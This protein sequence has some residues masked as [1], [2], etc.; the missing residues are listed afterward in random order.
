MDTTIIIFAIALIGIIGMIILKRAELT[1]GK[2][3]FLSRLGENTDHIVHAA[4]DRVYR[5]FSHLNKNN[6]ISSIQWVAYHV[7]SWIRGGYIWIRNHAHS[8]PHSKK[9]LD[10]VRGRGEVKRGA[11]SFYLKRI[12]ED[13]KE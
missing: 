5:F 1:S 11:A 6:F 2:K 13:P 8:H 9:V 10:M 12:A 3:Y 4:Y 7:L